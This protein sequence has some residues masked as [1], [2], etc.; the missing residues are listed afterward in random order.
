M[1]SYAATVVVVS[2]P[3][4]YFPSQGRYFALCLFRV[5]AAAGA[6]VGIAGLYGISA[7][8]MK[9]LCVLRFFSGLK[10]VVIGCMLSLERIAV[11]RTGTAVVR[12]LDFAAG[13]RLPVGN[14]SRISE[15]QRC[16]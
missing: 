14:P 15:F 4:R 2:G 7:E 10:I 5:A 13:L 11:M 3:R 6:A 1:K 9:L 8:N 12:S 16:S